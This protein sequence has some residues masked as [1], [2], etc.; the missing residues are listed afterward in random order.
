MIDL[1]RLRTEFADYLSKHTHTRW[2]MDAA[3]LHCCRISYEQGLKD[4]VVDPPQEAQ[5][6]WVIDARDVRREGSSSGSPR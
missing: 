6:P 3:L 4:A 5:A 2:G 1:D